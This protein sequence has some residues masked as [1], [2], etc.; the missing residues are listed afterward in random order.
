MAELTFSIPAQ[1]QDGYCAN[2]GIHNFWPPAGTTVATTN[3]NGDFGGTARKMSAD[4]GNINECVVALLRFDTSSLPDDATV[5][6]AVLRLSITGKAT[7]EAWA[8]NFE[9]YDSGVAISTD[10]Y[11]ASPG[12]NAAQVA[13][14]T[15]QAWATTGTVDVTL[16]NVSNVSKTGITGIRYGMEAGT[17]S[18]SGDVDTRFHVAEFGHATRAIPQLIVTYTESAD[19]SVLVVPPIRRVF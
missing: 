9:W 11:T 3:N 2:E 12:S 6:A 4:S 15:W 17:P 5:T 7:S 8:A 18:N 14:G 10:D 19:P 16:S 1:D 13:S